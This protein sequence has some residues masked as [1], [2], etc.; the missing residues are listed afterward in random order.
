MEK[1]EIS[2]ASFDNYSTSLGAASTIIGKFFE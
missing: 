2:I 1:L